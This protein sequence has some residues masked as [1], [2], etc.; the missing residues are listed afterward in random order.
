LQ[1]P[2][3]VLAP[4][5][6]SRGGARLVYVI[7]DEQDRQATI[8]LRKFLRSQGFEV[9][10]PLFEGGAE[11]V[12]R[13]NEDLLTRCDGVIV[14][15]GAADPS[16]KRSVESDLRKMEGLHAGGLA[17]RTYT[18]L[19]EKA[20]AAKR[21]ILDMDEPRVIDG[22]DGFSEA[23]LQPFLAALDGSTT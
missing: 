23:A 13:N 2:A 16:W 11:A 12:R 7:C 17:Q 22:L 3:P 9:Q 8:P 10:I 5:R 21:D 18:Y 14:F 1:R 6:H 15:Y 19:A 20:T 4:P